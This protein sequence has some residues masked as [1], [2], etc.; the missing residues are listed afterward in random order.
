MNESIIT[1]LVKLFDGDDSVKEIS[2]CND[3][4]PI[5]SAHYNAAPI[6]LND[7]NMMN[8]CVEDALSIISTRYVRFYA[9][10]KFEVN[11]GGKVILKDI[12]YKKVR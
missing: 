2:I 4:L 3:V 10:P 5:I 9:V 11:F 6:N 1:K 8:R 7:F 12:V